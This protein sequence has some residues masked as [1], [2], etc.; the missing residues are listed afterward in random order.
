MD[1]TGTKSNLLTKRCSIQS[2]VAYYIVY[3]RINNYGLLGQGHLNKT[4]HPWINSNAFSPM[5]HEKTFKDFC[6]I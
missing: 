6:S 5:I 4:E 1:L 2:S 3:S